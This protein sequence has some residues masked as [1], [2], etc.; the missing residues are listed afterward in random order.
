MFLLLVA[1]DG[2][3]RWCVY[4]NEF[5][6]ASV[7]LMRSQ[8]FGGARFLVTN[9][10][11]KLSGPLSMTPTMVLWQDFQY[12]KIHVCDCALFFSTQH[13]AD[14]KRWRVKWNYRISN[15]E[16]TA[17]QPNNLNFIMQNLYDFFSPRVLKIPTTMATDDTVCWL[18]NTL[19]YYSTIHRGI[20]IYIYTYTL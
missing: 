7:R 11:P 17:N 15:V 1:G 18:A 6:C 3:Q 8:L 14:W 20:Y 4:V 16:T 12:N 9:K 10:R 5:V 13:G 19:H 2:A